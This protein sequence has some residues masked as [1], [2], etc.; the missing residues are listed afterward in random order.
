M[1]PGQYASFHL[2]GGSASC[3]FLDPGVYTIASAP[4]VF[5]G[6]LEP[7]SVQ[8]PKTGTVTLRLRVARSP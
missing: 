5:H 4:P 8:V 6:E 7:S 3:A 1:R 2:S